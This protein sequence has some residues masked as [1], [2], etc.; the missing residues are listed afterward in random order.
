MVS[1]ARYLLCMV[2]F[3]TMLLVR[4]LLGSHIITV[5]PEN[6]EESKFCPVITTHELHVVSHHQQITA[7]SHHITDLLILRSIIVEVGSV[8]CSC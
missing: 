7:L 3:Y 1:G 8:C 5:L 4:H 2:P 6:L